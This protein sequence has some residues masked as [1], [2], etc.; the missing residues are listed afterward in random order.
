M[1]G[2][3]DE[4]HY[5]SE[6]TFLGAALYAVLVPGCHCREPVIQQAHIVDMVSHAGQ[7]HE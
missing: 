1:K 4:M 5:A 2:C 3:G 7:R 6:N